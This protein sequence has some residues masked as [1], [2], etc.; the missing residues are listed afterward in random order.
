MASEKKPIESEPRHPFPARYMPP[1]GSPYLVQDDDDWHT[2]ARKFRI[3]VQALI[4]F[5]FGTL[6]TNEVNWYMRRSVGCHVPSPSGFNWTF[7]LAKPGMIY[8]PPPAFTRSELIALNIQRYMYSV[9]ALSWIDPRMNLP[10]VDK[11]GDPGDFITREAILAN[12]GY[13]FANFLEASIAIVNTGKGPIVPTAVGDVGYTKDCGMYRAPSFLNIPSYAYPIR[14]FAPVTVNGGIEFRQIV[15]C[16]TQSAEVAAR[17]LPGPMGAIGGA[18]A[19]KIFNFPP[20][21]TDLKLTI[22]YDGTYSSE[23]VAYSL[24]P[25]V[26]FYENSKIPLIN[27]PGSSSSSDQAYEKKFGY[28]GNPNYDNWITAGKGWGKQVLGPSATQ[29]NPWGV[30]K[31]DPGAVFGEPQRDSN[32]V[33]REP[34]TYPPE[35]PGVLHRGRTRKF[36]GHRWASSTGLV[37]G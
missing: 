2:V 37:Q 1:G 14:L 9:A 29:G 23:L 7:R 22:R 27:M 19:Q 8:I 25:S 3:N 15:G 31:P 17:N 5:N 33:V 12:R 26:S 32:E 10:E 30:T 13:R 28:N 16:R 36:Q 35:S 34:G 24:F 18:I 20:I 6:N 11:G 21:W 4:M